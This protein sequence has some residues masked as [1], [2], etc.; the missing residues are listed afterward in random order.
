MKQVRVM[1]HTTLNTM[2]YALRSP[3]AYV[4]F[5]LDRYLVRCTTAEGSWESRAG[6]TLPLHSVGAV[7]IVMC[8]K[9]P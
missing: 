6:F 7:L 8:G 9:L 1:R 5:K 2:A 4:R 3:T